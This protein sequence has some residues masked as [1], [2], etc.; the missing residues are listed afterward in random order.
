ML[1][2]RLEGPEAT[3]FKADR[4]RELNVNIETLN[5]QGLGQGLG[6]RGRGTDAKVL[7]T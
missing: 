3:A 1:N 4:P 5:L 6:F 2:W 7:K